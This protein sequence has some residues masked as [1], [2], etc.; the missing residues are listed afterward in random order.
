MEKSSSKKARNE[1][2]LIEKFKE[3]IETTHPNWKIKTEVPIG[4]LTA[5]VRIDEVDEK[6]VTTRVVAYGEVKSTEDLGTLLQGYA[7]ALYY[8][9]QS[10]SP[11][12]LILPEKSFKKLLDSGKEFD[13]RVCVYNVDK[14]KL[15]TLKGVIEL[16]DK[17]KKKR[18]EETPLFEAWTRTYIIETITPLGITSPKYDEKGNVLFNLGVRVRALIRDFLKAKSP[19]LGDYAKFGIYCEPFEIPIAKKDELTY[20]ERY[21]PRA[22]HSAK[23]TLYE[24]P[25]PRKLKFT[26]HCM[27]PKITP[28]ILDEAIREAGMFTGI[29]DSHADGYHGRFKL[30]EILK[31]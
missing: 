26:V 27:T 4:K 23:S 29:G 5:D 11:A 2:E 14:S 12:W 16:R 21:V 6:G 31:I 18:R 7:K 8:A 19:S 9:E 30:I 1:K 17:S 24:I 10:G 20:T 25:P 22:G 13:A 15:E 28:E 3:I